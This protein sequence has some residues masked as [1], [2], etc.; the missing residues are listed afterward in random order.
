MEKY[1][2]VREV[3]SYLFFKNF[4]CQFPSCITYLLIFKLADG[5]QICVLF[6]LY[7]S[8]IEIYSW[9]MKDKKNWK[10]PHKKDYTDTLGATLRTSV[11]HYVRDALKS[12]FMDDLET[13]KIYQKLTSGWKMHKPFWL[14]LRPFF[15]ISL[16][17]SYRLYIH[18]IDFLIWHMNSTT[19]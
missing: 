13:H 11:S 8:I 15:K 17:I 1:P 9:D 16:P 6:L 10:I 12:C 19:K 4:F 2:N 3:F 7:K 18:P 5:S 14:R